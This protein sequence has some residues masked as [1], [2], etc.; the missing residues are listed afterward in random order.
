M[1]LFKELNSISVYFHMTHGKGIKEVCV[2]LRRVFSH[3]VTAVR[4]SELG[5]S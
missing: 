1:L 4:C 2:C 3:L 5:L